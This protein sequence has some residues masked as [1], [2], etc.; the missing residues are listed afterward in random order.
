[1][2]IAGKAAFDLK[3]KHWMYTK[4]KT[5]KAKSSTL[6]MLVVAR[7]SFLQV[8]KCEEKPLGIEAFPRPSRTK[9]VI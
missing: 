1:M 3:K 5:M 9:S 2:E 7:K 8:L 6:T 4:E